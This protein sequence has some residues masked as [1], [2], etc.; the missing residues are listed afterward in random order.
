MSRILEVIW[1]L[2]VIALSGSVIYLN[3]SDYLSILFIFVSIFMIIINYKKISI[4]KHELMTINLYFFLLFFSAFYSLLIENFI[5]M[6]LITY[7]VKLILIYLGIKVISIDRF[8][9]LLSK[10]ILI[11]SIISF[12]FYLIVIIG[13]K[14]P[15]TYGVIGE[16]PSYFY[17][18]RTTGIDF[19]VKF[20]LIRNSGIFYE[21]GLYQVFLNIALIHFY[22]IKNKKIPA[23][24]LVL[25]I[26]TTLSPIG[27][28]VA[29]IILSSKF[30]KKISKAQNFIVLVFLFITTLII[31]IPFLESKISTLSFQLRLYDLK[32]GINLIFKN[33]FLGIGFE[34]HQ[35]YITNSENRFG[36]A[37]KN[38]NGLISLFLQNGILFGLYYLYILKN[39]LKNS[40]YKF[41]GFA[42]LV[43]QLISQPI[44]ASTLFM[45]F[46]ASGFIYFNKK[47]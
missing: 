38:S 41:I 12:S 14:L 45:S 43:I 33:I 40:G 15:I 30:M 1:V 5:S 46:I 18:L 25:F 27:L 9:Y 42:I 21:P 22:L 32:Q 34:N 31:L 13:I 17:I 35:G 28:F 4:V 2:A 39:G 20:E 44:Y 6:N 11:L 26:L 37:R 10:I 16:I 19:N 7:S 24:L 47:G 3:Y 8:F 36:L 23:F 29:F